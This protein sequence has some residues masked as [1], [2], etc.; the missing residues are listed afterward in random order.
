LIAIKRFTQQV[1]STLA[2]L[3]FAAVDLDPAVLQQA[4]EQIRAAMPDE[5]RQAAARF[6]TQQSSSGNVS[7]P[8]MIRQAADKLNLPE[9]L[10]LW[11]LN[12][13]EL[14]TLI[15]NTS[16]DVLKQ[17]ASTV[18]TLAELV[19]RAFQTTSDD[20]GQAILLT[21]QM[22]FNGEP[23]Q[24]QPVHIHVFHEKGQTKNDGSESKPDTWVRITLQPEY[25][26]QVDTVFHLYGE[27]ILDIRVVFANKQASL[28]FGETVPLIREACSEFP[29]L[30]GDVSVV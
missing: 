13:R 26:G 21:L 7:I 30:L 2:E 22:P 20:Q 18:R 15:E 16:P 10:Q 24:P 19:N 9:L 3:D 27:D 17:S 5:L 29:F 11:P 28:L 14:V 6:A 25:T 12:D 4:R 8:L 23:A 1:A